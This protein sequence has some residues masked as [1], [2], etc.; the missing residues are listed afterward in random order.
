MILFIIAIISLSSFIG[1]QLYSRNKKKKE[2]LKKEREREQ[3]KTRMFNSLEK[4]VNELK[5]AKALFR[6]FGK[7]A[8]QLVELGN[9]TKKINEKLDDLYMPRLYGD[10]GNK[11]ADQLVGKI[12]GMIQ[13]E[14]RLAILGTAEI[15]SYD[16]FDVP[17]LND[18]GEMLGNI[19]EA[20]RRQM[21]EASGY[22][23]EAFEH[24]E[25]SSSLGEG[26]SK[27]WDSLKSQIVDDHECKYHLGKI[28]KG[29]ISG[30]FDL[31]DGGSISASSVHSFGTATMSGLS[32]Y[33]GHVGQALKDSV[34]LDFNFNDNSGF[35]SSAKSSFEDH[36]ESLVESMDGLDLGLEDA[37]DIH[38]PVISTAIESGKQISLLKQNKTDTETALSHILVG[39][40]GKLVGVTAGAKVGSL[41][42]F[43]VP[44]PG[45]VIGGAIGGLIGGIF[46]GKQVKKWKTRDLREAMDVWEE[47]IRDMEFEVNKAG[48]HYFKK[49]K[50]YA[51][52]KQQQFE[53]RKKDL[54]LYPVEYNVLERGKESLI[55]AIRKDLEK[56]ESWRNEYLIHL[57]LASDH[58]LVRKTNFC[59]KEYCEFIEALEY[60]YGEDLGELVSSYTHLP[61]IARGE[62]GIT[63]VKIKKEIV[64]HNEIV[65]I[66]LL[67]WMDQIKHTYRQF[68]ADI[69][70]EIERHGKTFSGIQSDWMQKVKNAK[71]NV[72]IEARKLGK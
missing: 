57:D 52:V 4:E 9:R 41:L 70:Q 53:S 51:S 64:L 38:F 65:I 2:L 34:K 14:H 24:A 69:A 33:S 59:I 71:V 60:T 5:Y 58:D 16:L 63:L 31:A 46:A 10:E 56:I 68:L 29:S 20:L 26:I 23:S 49:V 3:R 28:I 40:G 39:T 6:D 42:G 55:Q 47:V 13:D 44:G 12:A 67:G 27:F 17:S 21:P 45:N 32:H 66:G 22:L 62:V 72:D 15:V 48:R 25:Y 18:T 37:L 8:N 36:S 43:I 61:I 11:S 35:L 1:F 54:Y 50:Q 19:K 7:E 30:L